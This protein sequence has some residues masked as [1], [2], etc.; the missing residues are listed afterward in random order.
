MAQLAERFSLPVPGSRRLFDFACM[1]FT[2]ACDGKRVVAAV[3]ETTFVGACSVTAARGSG[4]GA[5]ELGSEGTAVTGARPAANGP[6]ARIALYEESASD[7]EPRLASARGALWG[8]ARLCE[9]ALEALTGKTL[10]ISSCRARVGVA[11][12][13]ANT[14]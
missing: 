12:A 2:R 1:S 4:A 7:M 3:D 5:I 6:R 14:P 9:S 11:C 10:D 8:T 13:C